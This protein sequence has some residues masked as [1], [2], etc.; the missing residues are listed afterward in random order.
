MSTADVTLRIRIDS[1]VK[2]DADQVLAGLGLSVPEAVRMLLARIAA[3]RALPFDAKV[4]NALT[5]STLA[6]SDE[7]KSLVRCTDAQEMFERLGI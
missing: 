1:Q 2:Q 5:A 7:G 4:P 6:E 3:E